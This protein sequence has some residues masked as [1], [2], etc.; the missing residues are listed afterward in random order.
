MHLA[1]HGLVYW[2][3]AG[4]MVIKLLVRDDME[5]LCKPCAVAWREGGYTLSMNCP[6]MH[7]CQSKERPVAAE[8]GPRLSNRLVCSP[9]LIVRYP[10]HYCTLLRAIRRHYCELNK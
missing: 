2:T 10:A 5:C 4:S 9:W 3:R 1:R 8:E 7:A 6:L